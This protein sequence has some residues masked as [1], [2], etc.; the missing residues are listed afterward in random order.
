MCVC[1]VFSLK[2]HLSSLIRNST[3]P[4]ESYEGLRTPEK[5]RYRHGPTSDFRRNNTRD[6]T[7]LK[8]PPSSAPLTGRMRQT[9]AVR[10]PAGAL[11]ICTVV[12]SLGKAWLPR[13]VR[14][15]LAAALQDYPHQRPTREIAA[16]SPARFRFQPELPVREPVPGP[17]FHFRSPSVPL[18]PVPASTAAGSAALQVSFS[19]GKLLDHM[20]QGWPSQSS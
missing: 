20:F 3:K 2:S 10:Q 6:V 16:R 12:K 5:P 9:G 1:E 17:V 15:S 14:R 4:H 18:R 8:H 19:E 11:A 7:H 13:P